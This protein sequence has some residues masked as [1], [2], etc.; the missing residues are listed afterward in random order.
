M[1]ELTEEERK[2]IME[3]VEIFMDKHERLYRRFAT[4]ASRLKN[5]PGVNHGHRHLRAVPQPPMGKV[6]VLRPPVRVPFLSWDGEAW[7][8]PDESAEFHAIEFSEIRNL[9]MKLL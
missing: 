7:G 4:G 8:E 3:D 6:V 5:E 9:E 1:A 2:A